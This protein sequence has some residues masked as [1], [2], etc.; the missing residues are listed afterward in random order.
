MPPALGGV[1]LGQVL[2]GAAPVA[3]PPLHWELVGYFGGQQAV[4]FGDWK[5]VATQTRSATPTFALYD[6]AGDPGGTRD[7]AAEHPEAA[8]AARA[9]LAGLH[10]PHPLFPLLPGEERRS[11]DSP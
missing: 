8:A 9:W 10:A 3:R 7:R 5:A 2:R 11:G 4:R 6:L 1:D